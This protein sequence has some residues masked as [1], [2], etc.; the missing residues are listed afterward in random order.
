MA[1]QKLSVLSLGLAIGILCAIY[2]FF[3]GA[4]AWLFNWGTGLVELI[5]SLYIGFSATLAG[6]I[7]GAVWAF[8]DGFIAGVVIAALYNKFKK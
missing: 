2:M 6:S 7:I 1:K 5:S 3:I 8:I 4:V